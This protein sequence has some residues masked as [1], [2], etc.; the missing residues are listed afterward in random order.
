MAAAAH[1][2]YI[3]ACLHSLVAARVVVGYAH[4]PAIVSW[5]SRQPGWHI[6]AIHSRPLRKLSTC[7]N[8]LHTESCKAAT[9]IIPAQHVQAWHAFPAS[10]SLTAAGILAEARTSLQW[11]TVCP[12]TSTTACTTPNTLLVLVTTSDGM[13]DSANTR[14]SSICNTTLTAGRHN[15]KFA[16]K[17]LAHPTKQHAQYHHQAS[18]HTAF[19]QQQPPQSMLLV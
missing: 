1:H 11:W 18:P 8:L 7:L 13:Q 19:T 12:F 9:T 6:H 15:G 10:P 16:C 4:D 3:T 5:H 14:P 2:L 17:R